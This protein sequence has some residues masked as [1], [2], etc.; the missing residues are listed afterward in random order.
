MGEMKKDFCLNI[1]Q[2]FLE[3]IDYRSYNNGSRELIPGCY[4]PQRKCRPSP[5]VVAPTLEY[6]VGVPSQAASSG[7]EKKRS[8]DQYPKGP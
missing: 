7:R 2:Q 8:P 4:N 5:S 6:L 1:R 3:N